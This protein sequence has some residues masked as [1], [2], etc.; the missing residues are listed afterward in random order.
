M[1]PYRPKSHTQS[2]KGDAQLTALIDAA[3]FLEDLE[4]F[5]DEE[6]I[7]EPPEEGQCQ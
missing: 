6:D 2:V 4:D 3:E 7:P 5:E 1:I